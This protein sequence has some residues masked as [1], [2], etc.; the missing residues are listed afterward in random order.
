MEA[1]LMISNS[2]KFQ[3]LLGISCLFSFQANSEK[4]LERPPFERDA[5]LSSG[6]T[7]KSLEKTK[8]DNRQSPV[9]DWTFGKCNKKLS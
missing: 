8:P 5:H 4:S 3:E 9:Q 7:G 2:P 1:K 6:S